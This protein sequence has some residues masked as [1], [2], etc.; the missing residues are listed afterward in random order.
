MGGVFPAATKNFGSRR[1][2]CMRNYRVTDLAKLMQ[3]LRKQ[4]VK[5]LGREDPEFGKS[6]WIED[7]EGNRVES[8]EPPMK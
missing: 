5:M 3:T 4:R 6:A 8:W 1:Q 2:E 7:A